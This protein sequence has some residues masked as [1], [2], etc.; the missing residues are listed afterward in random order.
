MAHSH[1]AFAL[2]YVEA[3]LRYRFGR[4]EQVRSHYRTYPS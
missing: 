3:Y 2:V 4:W 1:Y